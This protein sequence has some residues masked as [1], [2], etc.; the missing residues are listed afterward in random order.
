M[1]RSGLI[2]AGSAALLGLANPAAAHAQSIFALGIAAGA[3]VPTGGL[4]DRT[5]TGY[6]AMVTLSAHAPLT[7][8]TLRAEGMFNS[9]DYKN[10]G[11]ANATASAHVWAATANAIYTYSPVL[12]PYLIGGVGYYH[13]T[14]SGATGSAND[15]GVNGGVGFRLAL[16]GFSAYAEARYHYVSGSDVR[17]VPLTVGITF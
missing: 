4:G 6:H 16:T 11:G 3:T 12:G 10:S 5:N 7:P 17:M 9:L 15:F 1:S 8:F 13:T 2:A 14:E